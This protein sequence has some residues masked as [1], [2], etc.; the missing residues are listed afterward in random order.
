MLSKLSAYWNTVINMKPSQFFFRITKKL[1]LKCGL[2]VRPGPYQGRHYI[3]PA[4]PELDFDP[5][6]LSRFPVE[7]LMAGNVMF[8][9]HKQHLDPDGTWDDP[10]QSPLW[11]F[12]L[13]YFEFLFPLIQEYQQSGNTACLHKIKNFISGW[14]AQNPQSKKGNGWQPYTVAVRLTNWLSCFSYLERPF[15]DDEEFQN[16]M[17]SSIYEQF[18]FLATHLEKDILAN[19][20][21][22]D[23]KAL[24]LCA[25]FFDDKPMLKASIQ[26]LK[27][28][29]AEQILLDGMHFE[30]S[31]M[32]HKIILEDLIRV[33]AA[34]RGR[35]ITVSDLGAAIQ[36]ML[37]AAYSLEA[38]LQRIPLFNDCGSNV[39]KSLDA[40][41]R[42]GENHFQ[43][44]PQLQDQLPAAGYYI[45]RNGPW[46]LI[47]DAGS[48]GAKYTPGHAHCDAMSFELFK[49]GIPVLVNCGTYAYQSELRAFFRSTSAHNTVMVNDVEQS[50]CWGI[51]RMGKRS[52]VCVLNRS[53]NGL[54]MQMRDQKNQVVQRTLLLE[55]DQLTVWDHAKGHKLT[56]NYHLLGNTEEI[57]DG[58]WENEHAGLCR[59]TADKCRLSFHP[60]AQE[61]GKFSEVRAIELEGMDDLR[62]RISF[63]E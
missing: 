61:Y 37:N 1:H 38:G 22:E 25:L 14:I 2:G 23:L 17:L 57:A 7:E 47:A 4:V 5:S 48:P 12:N 42:A 34:L 33:A 59:V 13:H 20:Y 6:F 29:C 18:C 40:L 19:H 15:A 16:K 49:N 3:V 62:F 41:L 35:G 51:F 56:A 10:E 21:F 52:R 54:T 32:Y 9:H 8:L 27:K 44:I 11:N 50:Q 63:S 30:L 31:P 36:R 45:F 39:A 43:I 28:Q 60:Y 26:A 53:Q 58:V 55:A 46:T 24:V